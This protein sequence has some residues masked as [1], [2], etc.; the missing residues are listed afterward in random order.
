MPVQPVPVRMDVGGRNEAARRRQS[1][2]LE[3]QRTYSTV[4]NHISQ[5][6]HSKDKE[7]RSTY[8]GHVENEMIEEEYARGVVDNEGQQ[9]SSLSEGHT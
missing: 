5:V 7:E 6:K 1:I 4:E 2:A 8:E 3:K 9:D